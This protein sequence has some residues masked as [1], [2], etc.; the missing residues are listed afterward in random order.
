MKVTHKDFNGEY[1]TFNC[2]ASSSRLVGTRIKEV[3]LDAFELNKILNERRSWFETSLM[4]R[5]INYPVT[6]K[7][8]ANEHESNRY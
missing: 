8:T 6:I 7:I 4:T 5:F 1:K 3:E 2:E